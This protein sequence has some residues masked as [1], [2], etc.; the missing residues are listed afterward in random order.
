MTA[1][2]ED[3]RFFQYKKKPRSRDFLLSNQ[4]FA[5]LHDQPGLH[6]CSR[7]FCFERLQTRGAHFDAFVAHAASLQI[8]K[9]LAF[10]GDV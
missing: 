6:L 4:F 2:S 5:I 7:H 8:G 3:A 10:G 9:L 1:L